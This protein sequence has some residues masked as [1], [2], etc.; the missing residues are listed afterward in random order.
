[1]A[2][3]EEDEETERQL[4]EVRVSEA[5]DLGGSKGAP[6]AGVVVR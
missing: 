3:Q 1:M 5:D 4:R 2:G 6:V